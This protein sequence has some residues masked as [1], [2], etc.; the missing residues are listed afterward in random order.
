[1]MLQMLVMLGVMMLGVMM[2]EEMMLME[3]RRLGYM[4]NS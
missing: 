2:P 4:L 3:M 1:M